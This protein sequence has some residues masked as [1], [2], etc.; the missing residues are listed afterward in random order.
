[1]ENQENFSSSGLAVTMIFFSR[2]VSEISASV[3]L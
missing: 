3:G 2:S 1:M